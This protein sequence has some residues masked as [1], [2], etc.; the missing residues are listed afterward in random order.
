MARRKEPR[1]FLVVVE[2][3]GLFGAYFDERF[4]HARA[5]DVEGVVVDVPI[6]ADYRASRPRAEGGPG[7]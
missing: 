2:D 6:V 7:G 4:A 5:R 3:S 1:V